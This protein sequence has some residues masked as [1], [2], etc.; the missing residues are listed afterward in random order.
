M[1]LATAGATLSLTAALTIVGTGLTGDETEPFQELSDRP[2]LPQGSPIPGYVGAEESAIELATEFEAVE[3]APGQPCDEDDMAVSWSEPNSDYET[4]SHY[5]PVGPRPDSTQSANGFVYCRGFDF[6]YSGFSV[7]WNGDNWDVDLA[8]DFG[9][10]AVHE[11]GAEEPGHDDEGEEPATEEPD[12]RLDT[13]PFDP[14]YDTA[15]EVR[16]ILDL[17]ASDDWSEVFEGLPIEDL[18]TYE[19][20]TTCSPTP[21]PG[22]VGFSE[23]VLEGFPYTGTSGIARDCDQGNRSEHKE[24]RAWDWSVL[25]EDDRDARAA[26]QVIGW[27][28]ATDA[29]GNEYALARR[30]GLM[31]IIYNQSI[32]RSYAPEEGWVGYTGPNPHTDHVHFSFNRAGGMGETS[33]WDVA[34]LPDVSEIGFG[35]YAVLPDAG[36]TAPSAEAVGTTVRET[37]PPSGG[38]GGAG[39]PGR[40][41]NPLNPGGGGGAPAPGDSPSSPPVPPAVP[42]SR[43]QLPLPLPLPTPPLPGGGGGDGDDD[44]LLPTCPPGTPV[45]PLP[46]DCLLPDL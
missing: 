41:S 33:F 44:G 38:G 21:K 15:R 9:G 27:L 3:A 39:G 37:A 13:G 23:L 14:Q 30:T 26:A 46:T 28:L 32:W 7:D 8:P 17:D 25:V 11:G 1:R 24:G 10:D 6:D 36:G 43:P 16:E 12:D 40:P 20:Q 31:Y 29:E 5:A 22:T 2:A 18:A 34:E 45:V 35:P 19:P 42:P 4:G